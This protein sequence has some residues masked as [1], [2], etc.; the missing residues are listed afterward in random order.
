MCLKPFQCHSGILGGGHYV[1][2]ACNPNGKWYCYNDSSCKVRCELLLWH[3]LF[4]IFKMWMIYFQSTHFEIYSY[5][6]N[7]SRVLWHRFTL[8]CYTICYT[9][10]IVWYFIIS[11]VWSIKN[12]FCTQ[13]TSDCT[14]VI[15]NY[16]L[17]YGWVEITSNKY[18][19]FF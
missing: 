4:Y 19:F 13:K 17:R 9:G 7:I 14:S 12:H 6:T 15:T 5:H 2:Y 11:D 18:L 10:Y 16:S 8:Q 1:S 3:N